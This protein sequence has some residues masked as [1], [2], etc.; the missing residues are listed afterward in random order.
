MSATALKKS[1]DVKDPRITTRVT[2]D[3]HTLLA[4]AA[5]LVGSTINQFVVQA[6]YEK[7]KKV[8]EDDRFVF[9]SSQASKKFIEAL[10][11]PPKANDKLKTAFQAHKEHF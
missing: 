11:N 10:D 1:F 7:A 5:T 6:A 9:L 4:E 8:I 3:M 2:E